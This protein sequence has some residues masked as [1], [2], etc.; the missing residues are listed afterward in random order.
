M[1]TLARD[2]VTKVAELAEIEED[3]VEMDL[4]LRD[5]GVDSLMVLKLVAF[6]EKQVG[7]EIPESEIAKV[8][9]LG[10]ILARCGAPPAA[11]DE[12]TAEGTTPAEANEPGNGD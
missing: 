6:I 11:A 1:N 5:L 4:P 3:K 7:T 10:D 8:R 12:P 2:L 9:T